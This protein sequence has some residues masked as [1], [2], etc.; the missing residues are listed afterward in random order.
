MLASKE[1]NTTQ[2]HKT[3]RKAGCIKADDNNAR[4]KKKPGFASASSHKDQEQ[5]STTKS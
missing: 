5:I 3:I 2:V 1:E 4:I